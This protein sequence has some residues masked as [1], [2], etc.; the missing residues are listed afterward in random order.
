MWRWRG[1]DAVFG[2]DFG[3]ATNPL[4]HKGVYFVIYEI[5]L[6]TFGLLMI[7]GALWF[8]RRRMRATFRP[9]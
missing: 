5:T 3:E 1:A 4:F 6:D 8:A 7:G 9:P 2:A